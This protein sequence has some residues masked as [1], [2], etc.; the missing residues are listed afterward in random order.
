MIVPL[1][2]LDDVWAAD[3]YGRSIARELACG[4]QM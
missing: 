2:S 3:G 1:L 4:L